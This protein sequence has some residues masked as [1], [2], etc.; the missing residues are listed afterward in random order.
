MLAVHIKSYMYTIERTQRIPISLEEAWQFFKNPGNLS[1]ITH[2]E[3]GFQI[4]NK[5]PDEMY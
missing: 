3:M 1:K 2:L 4:L 5:V